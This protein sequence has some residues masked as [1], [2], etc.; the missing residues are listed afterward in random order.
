MCFCVW[1][2]TKK[3]LTY[4][5]KKPHNR[6]SGGFNIL[7]FYV[8]MRPVCSQGYSTGNKKI[9][10]YFGEK[11]VSDRIHYKRRNHVY[12]YILKV[13]RKLKTFYLNYIVYSIRPA[14]GF[15]FPPPSSLSLIIIIIHNGERALL[16]SFSNYTAVVFLLFPPPN[17]PP[18]PYKSASAAVLRLLKRKRF[19]LP[20]NS[21][22]DTK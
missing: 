15:S 5:N 16:F 14:T 19:S 2:R 17:P 6:E 3:T 7:F 20:P 1:K 9:K 13:Q 21:L 22:V 4:I 12:M 11:I 8:Q 10:K 18:E